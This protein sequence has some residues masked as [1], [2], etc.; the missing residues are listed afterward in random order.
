MKKRWPF[1]IQTKVPRADLGGYS[2]SEFKTLL[3][4]RGYTIPRSFFQ[5]CCIAKKG[6]RFYRFRHWGN[7]DWGAGD[8]FVIDISCPFDD[9]DRWANSTDVTLSFDVWRQREHR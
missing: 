8:G 2:R 4:R 1:K 9:F 3:K 6:G 7:G 5:D